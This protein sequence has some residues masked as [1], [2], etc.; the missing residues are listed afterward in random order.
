MMN[1]EEFRQAIGADPSFDGGAEHLRECAACTAYR[2]DIRRLE[3]TIGRALAIEVPE[4]ALPELPDVDASNVVSLAGRRRP[5]TWFALAATVVLAA[6]LGVRLMAPGPD[7][8][9]LSDQILAHLDGEPDALRVTDVAV[10]DAAVSAVV[11]ANVAV[12]D[13][14]AGLIS[15]ARSCEINGHDV[16]HLVI[17]GQ[18]GPVTILLMPEES[19]PGAVRIDG[20]NVEGVILPVGKGSIAIVGQHGE[21]LQKI[22]QAIVNS[23]TW[24]T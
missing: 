9:S 17:Q 19:V 23:V 15:Y 16:P 12:L 2:D 8:G 11:P 20:S 7:A 13:H 4:L 1:C 6:A 21:S 3:A 5:W 22:E 18:H 14:H 24:A 10:P